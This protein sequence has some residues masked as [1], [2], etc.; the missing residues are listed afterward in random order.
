VIGLGLYM[1]PALDRHAGCVGAIIRGQVI[2]TQ[3]G[4]GCII[5]PRTPETAE[6]PMMHMRVNHRVQHFCLQEER[7]SGGLFLTST[8]WAG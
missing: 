5:Q 3:R 1:H 2:G 6:A 4:K 8:R 7:R